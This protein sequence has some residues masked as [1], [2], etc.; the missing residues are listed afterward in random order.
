MT[1]VLSIARSSAAQRKLAP[2]DAE[3]DGAEGADRGRFGRAEDAGIDAADGHQEQ[4]QELPRAFHGGEPL[5]PRHAGAERRIVLANM[6]DH[7]HHGHIK[8]GENQPGD[9]AGGE[10]PRHRLLGDRGVDHQNDRRRN[11]DAEAAAGG[12]RAG[13]K[14]GVVAG[15]AHFRQRD[16]RHGGGGRHRRAAHRAEAGGRRQ[17][18]DREAAAHAGQNHARRLE[19]VGRQAGHRRDLAHQDEQRQHRQRIGG[20]DVERHGAGEREGRR[21]RRT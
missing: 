12:E 11:Q 6:R 13:G 8:P 21:R 5:A 9:Q 4:R 14:P 20:A 2:D 18:A 3:H 15:L 19:Q 1:T 17:R 10:Q 16:A 7:D